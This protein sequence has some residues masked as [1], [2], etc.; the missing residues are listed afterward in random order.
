MTSV[1]D[2]LEDTADDLLVH[3]L[4]SAGALRSPQHAGALVRPGI[5]LYGG[6]VGVGQAAPEAVVSLHATVAHT[7]DVEDGST[8]GYGATYTAAGPRRW[9]TLAIGYGDGL[10][11]ALGKPGHSASPRSARPHHRTDLHGRH[12]GRHHRST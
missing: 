8:L 12:G 1:L 3:V 9:A 11:R 4:N 10:P 5:F 2:R 7:R 6:G